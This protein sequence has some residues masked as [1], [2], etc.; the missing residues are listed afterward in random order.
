MNKTFDAIVIGGGHAGVEAAHALAAMGH[1]TLILSLTLDAI[2]FLACNPNIG[3]TGKGHLVKEIDALGGIMGILADKATIQTRMLNTGNGPAVQSLRA[4]VDKALYH[5]LAKA[6]LE[7]TPNLSILEG[8]AT[9]L[10]IENNTV[11]GIR[12]AMGDTYFA[13]AIILATGVYLD[14]RIIIGECIRETGPN[15]YIRSSKLSA[16]LSRLGLSIRRFKTGTPARVLASSIDFSKMIPQYGDQGIPAFSYMTDYKVRNDYL[17]YLTYTNQTTHKIILDNLD[18][19]PLYN[20]T[21]SGI[22]PRY[23]PSIESKIVRFKDKERHQ[24]FIEPEGADTTEM[25]VQGMSTSLP[26]DVQEK[27]LATIAGLENVKIMR[28]GYAIEYDCL[29]ATEFYPTLQSKKIQGFFSAGQSNGSSG[30]EEAAAQG[31]MAGINA[32]LYLEKREGLVLRRDQAYIGVLIDDLVTK[33]ADEPYRM[34]TSRAEYR[35]QLRQDNADIRLTEIGRAVGLVKDD[36]YQKY[37]EHT[38]EIGRIQKMLSLTFSPDKIAEVFAMRGEPLPKSGLSAKDFLRRTALNA[39]DLVKVSKEFAEVSPRALAYVETELKYEGYLEKQKR[40]IRE[41]ARL[42]ELALPAD[43]DYDK[44]EG[45]LTEAR[46]KLQK[47]KPLTIAQAS[48]I[49]GVTPA[50]ITVLIIYLKKKAAK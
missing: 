29:D 2:A 47:I 4:Q 31:L 37:L 17:C 45:L 15:G 38:A 10:L 21:I 1:N 18:K 33:G 30:Y 27:M 46:Q 14:S 32:A 8:E 40:E 12:T 13:K 42:E 25:Y 26:Y 19:A 9:E 24:V 3:G 28:Y 48:R 35:L 20:G 22:G 50:D 41:E 39:D 44:V 23:C 49:S 5:R 36:R 16:N 11:K 34:M 7:T 6:V 43:F